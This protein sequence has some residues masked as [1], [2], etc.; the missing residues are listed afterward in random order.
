MT[1]FEN[2]AI[3]LFAIIAAEMGVM[4]LLMLGTLALEVVNNREVRKAH[5]QLPTMF[6]LSGQKKPEEENGDQAH[7]H[8]YL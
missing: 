6:D 2:L 5:S 1:L 3:T 4:L 8:N 7:G